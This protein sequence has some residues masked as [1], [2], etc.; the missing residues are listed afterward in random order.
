MTRPYKKDNQKKLET[1]AIATQ[2][3]T[4]RNKVVDL[5]TK[6]TKAITELTCSIGELRTR[7]LEVEVELGGYLNGHD[8]RLDTLESQ[9]KKLFATKEE[10]PYTLRLS[11]SPETR[12]K[13]LVLKLQDAIKEYNRG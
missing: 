7:I 5:D 8:L 1:E 4:L 9:V 2:R 3:D 10:K 12:I 13:T 6:V 11:N